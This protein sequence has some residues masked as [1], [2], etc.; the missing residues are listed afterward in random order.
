MGN[1]FFSRVIRYTENWPLN[2]NHYEDF[3]LS[4]NWENYCYYFYNLIAAAT[5]KKIWIS[6]FRVE[7]LIAEK[8]LKSWK[9][10]LVLFCYGKKK[11]NSKKW[12]L[13]VRHMKWVLVEIAC[14]CDKMW[15]KCWKKKNRW[16]DATFLCLIV[17]SLI[18]IAL[19]QKRSLMNGFQWL[20]STIV[21]FIF[22]FCF[23][24]KSRRKLIFCEMHNY[25]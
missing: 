4:S 2:K 17:Q 3:Q 8:I 20:N 5:R 11:K 22:C 18:S 9:Y 25:Y 14:F 12:K 13:Q 16:S 7:S 1:N 6:P 19:S 24:T 10:F 23:M 21:S 15:A